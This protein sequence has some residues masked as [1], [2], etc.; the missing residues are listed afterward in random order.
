MNWI[1][2]VALLALLGLTLASRRWIWPKAAALS[3]L[4][5]ALNSWWL[6]D[7]L[8]GDGLNAATLYHLSADMEGT[9]LADFRGVIAAYVALLAA[10][11]LPLLAPL[12][13]RR[14]PPG[15]GAPV[16]AGFALSLLAA[17]GCS[18]LYGDGKRLYHQLQPVDYAPIAADYV[19]PVQPL[20]R[21]PNIVWIYGE[22]LERT[23][24]DEATFPGLMPN[25]TRLAAQALD[26]RGIGSAEGSGWTI[27]GLVS[28]MCGVPLTT[29]R[30]DENS[31][32]RM[33]RFL[34]EARCLGDYLH[35]QGYRNHYLGGA[36]G[37]FAGKGAFLASHGFDEVDDVAWFRR[38]GVGRTH[39]SAWGVHDDVLL[40]AAWRRFQQ[41]SRRGEPFMLT[42]LTMDTHHPAGHLPVA[43]KG[44]HYRSRH[45]DIG[46][47]N[48]LNCSDRLVSRL[49]ER[50]RSSPW[51]DNTV[52]VVASDHLAMPND[53]SEVLAGMQ[54]E[55]LLLFL[56]PGVAPHQQRIAQGT[57]LDSGATLLGLID[58]QVTALGFGRSLL[59]PDAQRTGI[60]AAAYAA[61]DIGYRR[62]LAF[63]RSLWT[64]PPDPVLR[65]DEK[66]RIVVGRQQVRPPVLL[67]Y[68]ERG[69]IRS[70]TLEDAL[71]RFNRADH[72]RP[73]AYVDRCTAFDDANDTDEW[74]ALL[75]DARH[76]TRLVHDAA[77][78]QGVRVDANAGD[79]VNVPANERI[80]RALVVARREKSMRAGQY[81]LR[82]QARD[83]PARAFWLEAVS[84]RDRAVLARQWVYPD[85]EGRIVMPLSL[86][87][88]VDDLEIQAW[89]DL[90]EQLAVDDYALVRTG[91]RPRGPLS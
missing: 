44:T 14:L 85:T 16:A 52:I 67:E 77:L 86:D 6:L 40:D 49:V 41:L 30:G 8:S 13:R 57:T 74:C 87:R 7:R 59:L 39:F 3:L 60:S 73:L 27:A 72:R 56:A 18:P 58:P 79:A 91:S 15:R 75:A 26:F 71:G 64:G 61:D 50:I 84:G 2:V 31:M 53:L 81:V 45:G 12:L 69:A 23:Y 11:L 66:Q 65:L 54:R 28:S 76:G 5:V 38:Q 19:Q 80:R 89:L 47:L 82:V 90:N 4:L 32:G 63:A 17:I 33:G 46:L 20:S 25:L 22:S 68:D 42:T 10:S 70:M 51:A 29:A 24:L 48:A 35:E 62:Y 88:D 55:N 1:L 9:G 36:A 37:E 34:P 43:C 21:R 83:R 78:R